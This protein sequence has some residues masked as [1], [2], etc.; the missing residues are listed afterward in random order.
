MAASKETKKYKRLAAIFTFI[1]VAL[2]LGPTAYYLV[3]GFLTASVVIEKV[4]LASSIFVSLILTMLC[5]INKWTFRSKIWLIILA[6]FFVI[7]HYLLMVMIFGF[8]QIAD[9]LIISP[10]AKHFRA[11]ASINKEIDKRMTTP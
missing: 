1:S 5:V 7:D 3:L 8:T 4:A 10:L 11:K 2:M 9:E 6:L